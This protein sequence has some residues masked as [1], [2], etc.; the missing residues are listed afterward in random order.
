MNLTEPSEA[1]PRREPIDVLHVDDRPQ[2]RGL[3]AEQLDRLGDE[4]SVRTVGSAAAAREVLETES[5]DCVVSD[6]EMP[7]GTGLD[8][9]ETVRDEYG[10][11]P[12]VLYTAHGSEEIASEAISRGVDD[13]V[14]KRTGGNTAEMLVNRIRNA[15]DR[16]RAETDY[17]EIF[18]KTADGIALHDPES[19]AI[20]DANDRYCELVGRER[21]AVVGETPTAFTADHP[22]RSDDWLAAVVR[23]E[24]YGVDGESERPDAERERVNDGEE[25]GDRDHAVEGD[26]DEELEWYVARPDGEVVVTEVRLAEARIGGRDLVLASARP[27]TEREQSQRWLRSVVERTDHAVFVKNVDGEYELVNEAA[28]E[29]VDSTREEML[30][31]TDRELFGSEEGDR[32]RRRDERV[33]DGES[34]SYDRHLQ[35]DDGERFFRNE[36]Y[37]LAG[38]TGEVEGLVGISTD[39]TETER[40]ERALRALHGVAT[41]LGS[42]ESVAAVCEQ[43]VETAEQILAFSHCCLNLAD[44]GSLVPATCSSDL[45]SETV[46]RVAAD[47]GV[48]GRVYTSGET[49]VTADTAADDDALKPDRYG[50]ALTVPIGDHGV[51]QAVAEE[52]DAFDERDAELA[53]ILANHARV[54]LDRLDREAT[55]ERQNERL[56]EITAVVSHDLQSP[57]NVA[58]GRLDLAREECDSEHLD[59]VATALDRSQELIDG[60]LELTSGGTADRD[61]EA[62]ELATAAEA[63]WVTVGGDDAHLVVETDATLRASSSRLRQL[64]ENLFGNAVEHGGPTVTVTVERTGDGFAVSDDGPGIPADEREA[65]LDAGYSTA[66]DGTG[67]GLSIVR[68]V[69]REHGWTV[70]VGESDDGGARIEVGGVWG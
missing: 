11:L 43:T 50:S 64:L 23:G 31:A 14:Q 3:L 67:L 48:V 58:S 61:T 32:I 16:H 38:P 21:D 15:V 5:V 25:L 30:G 7:D 63:A 9:L 42:H 13:Y 17:R 60:L 26:R 28:A 36:K 40:H 55:L 2:V 56:E 54:A 45:S 18:A 62:I 10:S 52:T 12:F 1:S 59:D 35:T 19:G 8:L 49:A 27:V 34:V 70:A 69:A 41:E 53:E 4:F 33:L 39:R 22:E 68:D 51:L 6:Y 66:R 37:P 44:D 65:V 24:A 57:L 20:V 47:E 29:A 46:E